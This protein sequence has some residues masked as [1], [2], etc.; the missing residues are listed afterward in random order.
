MS[1]KEDKRKKDN[2]DT[3]ATKPMSRKEYMRELRKLQ[4]E[5][6]DL[7]AWVKDKKIKVAIVFEGRDAAG[8][9]GTIRAIT[10]KVS[11]R[12]FRIVALPAPTEREKT[13]IYGQRYIQQLPAGGEI[14][15]FDRSWY[16]RAG[17]EPVMGFCTQ[18]ETDRFLETT[19]VFEKM[20]V[21]A[22]VMLLKYWLEVSNEEQERRF[23]RRINDPVRQWKL[24]PMDL[25]AR[26]RWY[27]YSRARDKML[28][29]TDMPYAP[30]YLIRSDDK[31]RARLNCIHHMLSKIPHEEIA[32]EKVKL[33]PRSKKD[34]YDDYASLEERYFIPELF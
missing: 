8:K 30:W 18:H 23:K 14:V 12:V 3:E 13:Q 4:V 2:N 26:R 19:P 33:P 17:V 22:G 27:A 34:A 7:Q 10:E 5:L 6:C 20:I 28:A 24:S 16:N 21:D 32:H 15:L 31:R 25:E 1:K 9:G 11:P 29:A